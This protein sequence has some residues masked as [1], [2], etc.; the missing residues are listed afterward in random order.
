MSPSSRRSWGFQRSRSPRLP[1]P[2]LVLSRCTPPPASRRRRPVRD[3]VDSEVPVRQG[4]S[5]DGQLHFH[6]LGSVFDAGLLGVHDPMR[7]RYSCAGRGHERGPRGSGIR[8][9]IWGRRRSNGALERPTRWTVRPGV[10]ARE[11]PR[12]HETPPLAPGRRGHVARARLPEEGAS[13]P[14]PAAA[15]PKVEWKVSKS[16]E[17]FRLSDADEGASPDSI[18]LAK[19]TVL[20]AADTDKVLARL[21]LSSRSPPTSRASRS[22]TCRRRHLA[23]ARRSPT[24]FRRP[25]RRLFR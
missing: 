11:T 20:S 9:T 24:R 17:G 1:R 21:F 18:P 23:P 3:G 12:S 8:G 16:G 10:T 14:P 7:A 5:R 6:G 4:G 22:A 19:A 2:R 15:T 25:T 13:P